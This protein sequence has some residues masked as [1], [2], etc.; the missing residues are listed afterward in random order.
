[1]HPVISRSNPVPYALHPVI[2]RS[3]PVPYALHPVISRS[4]PVPYVLNPVISRSNLVAY[5]FD[6]VISKSIQGPS[7]A[8]FIAFAP[9]AGGCGTVFVAL[10]AFRAASEPRLVA[11]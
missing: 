7:E 2:S 10:K 1:L 11:S 9:R 4:N 6:P 5:A 8:R 3:N